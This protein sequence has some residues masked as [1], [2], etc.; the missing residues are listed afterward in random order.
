MNIRYRAL[1]IA[2]S[3]A[4]AC[5]SPF[6]TGQPYPSKPITIVVPFSAGAGTDLIARRIAEKL[7]AR[8]GQPVLVENRVGAAG[9]IGTYLAKAPADENKRSF[10]HAGQLFVCATGCQ[11]PGGYDALNDFTPIIEVG[12]TPMFLVTGGSSGFKSFKD[13]AAAAR[14]R[15]WNSEARV[16]DTPYRR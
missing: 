16:L 6:A 10:V 7:S 9:V 14:T 5:F 8:I 4:L 11:S 13:V 1:S 15:K 3:F 12:E 2:A